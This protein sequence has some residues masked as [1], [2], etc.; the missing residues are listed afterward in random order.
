[1]NLIDKAATLIHALFHALDDT[2]QHMGAD[3][4]KCHEPQAFIMDKDTGDTL[5]AAFD[6]FME[7]FEDE[8]EAIAALRNLA[9]A[10]SRAAR[11][12]EA[13]NR[14]L[15]KAGSHTVK[16]GPDDEN[17]PG[18]L[19]IYTVAYRALHPTQETPR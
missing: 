5:N 3:E 1:M 17:D 8:H 2:A 18:F 12:E 15:H 10:E 6:I 4:C 7:G 13:L 16:A 11:A 14:V 19:G 9:A